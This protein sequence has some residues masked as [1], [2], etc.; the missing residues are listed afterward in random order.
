MVVSVLILSKTVNFSKLCAW[1]GTTGS[2]AA[3]L[4]QNENNSVQTMSASDNFPTIPESRQF[5]YPVFENPIDRLEKVI[6][7]K[8]NSLEKIIENKV[9]TIKEESVKSDIRINS[10]FNYLILVVGGILPIFVGVMMG[11]FFYLQGEIFTT[12]IALA[13]LTT[14]FNYFINPPVFERLAMA[15]IPP[16][17]V[18]ATGTP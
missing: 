3:L 15:E 11:I 6:D 14:D 13:Q 9:Q 12:N 4:S 8:H 1:W 2:S 16:L 7:E 18:N 10:K 5:V 17:T